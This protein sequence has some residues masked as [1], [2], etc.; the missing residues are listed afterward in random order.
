MN[1]EQ[2]LIETSNKIKLRGFSPKTNK[3]YIYNISK[4]IKWYKRNLRITTRKDIERYLLYLDDKKHSENSLRLNLASLNFCFQNVLRKDVANISEIPRP[5][6]KKQLPKVISKKEF[7]I[8]VDNIKNKKHKLMIEF[9]YSTGMRVSEFINFKR[10]D[11]NFEDNKIIIKQGKGKKDR[12]TIV[13][14][15]VTKRLMYYICNTNFKTDY[16]FET[17]RYQKYSIPTIQEI[18]KKSSI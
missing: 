7:K 1:N 8:L 10:Q 5:K 17:N 14:E 12:L 15:K 13:S 9:L 18:L 6:K 2:I 4:F 16:L 3:V 11:I